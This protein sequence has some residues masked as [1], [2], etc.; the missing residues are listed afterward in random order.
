MLIAVTSYC[1]SSCPLAS[2]LKA[3]LVKNEIMSPTLIEPP[4]ASTS[5]TVI[6]VAPEVPACH[7]L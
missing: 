7:L 1:L 4:E 2:V 5:V 6:V 3:E